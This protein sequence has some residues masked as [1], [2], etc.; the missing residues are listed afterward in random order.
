MGLTTV[1]VMVKRD[2]PVTMEHFLDHIDHIVKLVGVDHVGFGSDCAMTGWPTDP[3]QKDAFLG[4]Y[5]DPY[6][7]ERYRFRYP[8]SVDG[9][10]D[11]YKWK[12]V[13][14]GLLKRG[15]KDDAIAK[16]LGGNWLR[17]FA[18]VIG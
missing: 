13:T 1:N 3:A 7:D 15:Y 12:Y 17:V 8:L 5:G 18:D 16:I 11:Q 4:F 6:F 9:M 2:L 14:A 10:N